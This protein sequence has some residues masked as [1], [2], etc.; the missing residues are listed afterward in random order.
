METQDQSANF[1][2]LLYNAS[3]R[4]HIR[5]PVPKTLIKGLGFKKPILI[6]KTFRNNS[7]NELRPE[8]IESIITKTFI[9]K[10]NIPCAI[11]KINTNRV[12]CF[13]TQ[14]IIKLWNTHSEN[15]IIQEYLECKGGKPHVVRIRWKTPGHVTVSYIS[16]EDAEDENPFILSG[17][18][19]ESEVYIT[20]GTIE[21]T[22]YA[23]TLKTILEHSLYEEN[24]ICELVADF[25]QETT[26]KWYF[27]HIYECKL[28]KRSPLL[29]V[30][31][32]EILRTENSIVS[33]I[34][35]KILDAFS[36]SGKKTSITSPCTSTRPHTNFGATRVKF[37]EDLKFSGIPYIKSVKRQ[38]ELD[39]DKD[40][41]ELIGQPK[42]PGITHITYSQWNKR[43]EN[44][45]RI[46][47]N[48]LLY[49]S[50]IANQASYIK[51][52]FDQNK[53]K[54]KGLIETMTRLTAEKP[55]ES[56]RSNRKKEPTLIMPNDLTSLNIIS[57]DDL[58]KKVKGLTFVETKEEFEFGVKKIDEMLKRMEKVQ[59]ALN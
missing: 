15:L 4:N 45:K 47:P 42:N 43:M 41:K 5:F 27:I 16:H 59:G 32:A 52:R 1:F 7:F 38:K 53:S 31:S 58:R 12:I 23:D 36:L 8:E 39:L 50:K 17:T 14:E 2:Y 11:A 49:A 10:P 48:D 25:I 29:S 33:N 35:N 9:E 26:G 3:K 57:K 24:S 28:F 18:V 37:R 30:R 21:L 6:Q 55:P 44:H 51:R 34:P 54:I 56:N 22:R 46:T 40:I 20:I 13:T 19:Y